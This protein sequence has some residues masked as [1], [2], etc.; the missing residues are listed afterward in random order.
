MLGFE[1]RTSPL[2]LLYQLSYRPCDRTGFEPVSSPPSMFQTHA[3]RRK[4]L[5][6]PLA[7]PRL[8]RLG[9]PRPLCR[10]S[11]EARAS[12]GS[13]FFG[14]SLRRGTACCLPPVCVREGW[15]RMFRVSSARE[16]P[17]DAWPVSSRLPPSLSDFIHYIR[18]AVPVP[19][20]CT[21]VQKG[22]KYKAFS[23]PTPRY[24]QT[25]ALRIY[26]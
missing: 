24:V 5:R 18:P 17:L 3:G 12:V 7:L 13:W 10:T 22:S 11:E 8:Y 19:G 23:L 6:T 21:C 16:P 25:Q 26:L 14:P 2:G 9:S 20:L 1:P 15:G 4:W